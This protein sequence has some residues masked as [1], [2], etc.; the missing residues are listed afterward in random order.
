MS[1]SLYSLNRN[2][3]ALIFMNSAIEIDSDWQ[4]YMQRAA[5]KKSLNDF[6]GAKMDEEAARKIGYADQVII[7]RCPLSNTLR[8]NG[9]W[10][11]SQ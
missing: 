5:I 4:T 7:S 10:T 2:E 3:E 6:D 11:V 1:Y 9:H 8:P